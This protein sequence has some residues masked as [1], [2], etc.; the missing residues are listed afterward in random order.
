MRDSS[1]NQKYSGQR[2][3]IAWEY[4]STLNLENESEF[5]KLLNVIERICFNGICILMN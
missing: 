2:K 1:I 5:S 3:S 4:I